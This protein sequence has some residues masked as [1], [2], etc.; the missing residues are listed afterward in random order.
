MKL[1]V[2]Q[3]RSSDGKYVTTGRS[4]ISGKPLDAHALRISNTKSGL[5]AMAQ[6]AT[7]GRGEPI[8][9]Y[10]WLPMA[11]EQYQI[12]RNIKDYI[13]VPNVPIIL[14]DIPNTNGVA[15]SR[16]ELLKFNTKAGR[17]GYKTFKGKPTFTE[18]QN[19]DHTKAKGVIL[20]VYPDTLDGY[21]KGMIKIVELL[22][23]DRS[24]D[25]ELC[26]DILKMKKNCYSMGSYFA[27]FSMSDGSPSTEAALKRPL[28]CNARNEL[29]YKL[30]HDIDGFETSCVENP[31]Y[32]AATNSSVINL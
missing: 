24:K 29:V 8:D 9:A 26:N 31:A 2:T 25:P 30:V 17:L 13:I 27:S 4:V 10:H 1:H 16:E 19:S 3:H 32:V 14:S 23:F 15:F 18:H 21:G 20:D 12:S 6:T 22:A 28:W 11:A 7:G 5:R